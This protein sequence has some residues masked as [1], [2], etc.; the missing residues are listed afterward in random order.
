MP[1]V[2]PSMSPPLPVEAH[3]ISYQSIYFVYENKDPT[4]TLIDKTRRMKDLIIEDGG[5]KNSKSDQ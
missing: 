1:L 2:I 3:R 4:L 5:G